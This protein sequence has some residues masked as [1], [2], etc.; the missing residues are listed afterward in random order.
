MSV[1]HRLQAEILKET[2]AQTGEFELIAQTGSVGEILKW[3]ELERPH[4]WICC[5]EQNQSFE[6]VLSNVAAVDPDLAIV[7]FAPNQLTGIAQRPIHS[8][9]SLLDFARSSGQVASAI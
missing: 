5:W 9:T 7:R 4:L 3:I 8:V 1:E 6:D 2:L